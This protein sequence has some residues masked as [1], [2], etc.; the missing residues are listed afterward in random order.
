MCLFEFCHL[1]S[2]ARLQ[3]MKRGMKA[4][5]A[6]AMASMQAWKIRYVILEK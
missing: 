4:R 2:G 1:L 5:R 6:T 3:K